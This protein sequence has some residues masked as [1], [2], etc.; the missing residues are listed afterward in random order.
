MLLAGVTSFTI[1]QQRAAAADA[2]MQALAD[3]AALAGVNTLVT[4]EGQSDTQRLQAAD[5]AVRKVIAERNE[6]V[7][8][9]APSLDDMRISVA[10]TT[11]STGRGPAF[12]ATARYVPPGSAV[13]PAT[14]AAAVTKKRIRG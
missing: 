8:I 7:P 3:E 10:L 6:I 1:A 14:T 13:V 2:R 9:I 5:L 4:T 12:T 11:H